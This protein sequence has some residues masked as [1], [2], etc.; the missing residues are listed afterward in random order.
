MQGPPPPDAAAALQA[1]L[2]RPDPPSLLEC[3]ALI[4][5][6][7][8]GGAIHWRSDKSPLALAVLANRCDLV[9]S[10]LA[11]NADAG[12]NGI[13]VDNI[14][15]LAAAAE[16]GHADMCA[17]LVAHGAVPQPLILGKL[18]PCGL[19]ECGWGMHTPPV[20]CAGAEPRFA[21]V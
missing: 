11:Q 10:L 9:D 12:V 14:C 17:V 21:D 18:R 19:Y 8:A 1:A 7:Y 5:E 6:L 13:L 16:R 2:H 20:P 3:H 4:D 15:L